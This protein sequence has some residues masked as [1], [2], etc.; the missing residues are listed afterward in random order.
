MDDVRLLMLILVYFMLFFKV[1]F[2]SLKLLW[3]KQILTI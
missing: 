1:K 2:I 3:E